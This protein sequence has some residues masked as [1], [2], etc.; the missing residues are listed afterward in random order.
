MTQID[1]KVVGPVVTE[2]QFRQTT[3]GNYVLSYNVSPARVNQGGSNDDSSKIMRYSKY[4]TLSQLVNKQ[5]KQSKV[6]EIENNKSEVSRVLNSN[7]CR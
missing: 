3:N 1:Y 2:K 7:P 5:V 4:A 6:L